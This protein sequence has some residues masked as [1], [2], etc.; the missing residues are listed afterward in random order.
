MER[1]I[2]KP[3]YTLEY[4]QDFMR[5]YKLNWNYMHYDNMAGGVRKAALEDFEQNESLDLVVRE[6]G[7]VYLLTTIVDNDRFVIFTNY[8]T[9]NYSLEWKYYLHRR[10]WVYGKEGTLNR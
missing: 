2:E 4:V 3:N 6:K 5:K 9:R 1:N 8:G 7:H 10:N